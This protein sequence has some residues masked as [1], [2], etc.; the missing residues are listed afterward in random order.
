MKKSEGRIELGLLAASQWGMFTTAQAQA[1]GVRRCQVSR[2]VASIKVEPVCYGVYRFVDGAEPSQVE[3][4]AQWLSVFPKLTAAERL[5]SKKHDAVL[6]GST[7]ACALGAGNFLASPYTFIV[8]ARKQTSRG[9]IRFLHCRLDEEDVVYACGVP[10]TSFERTVYDLIR[11]DEDPDLIDKFMQ[12]AAGKAGHVFDLDRLGVLL[13]GV[14]S[15]HGFASGEAFASELVA[16][17]ASDVQMDRARKNIENAIIA[18]YGRKKVASF[19]AKM[20]RALADLREAS[21]A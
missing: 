4:K 5:S 21:D 18:T 13:S 6:A 7:A 19:E 3:V 1:L 12:D 2:M 16:R 20:T 15:R 17:N 14:A 11:L 9:D 8:R 10:A